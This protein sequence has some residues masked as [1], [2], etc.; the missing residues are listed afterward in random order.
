VYGESWPRVL[1][2]RPVLRCA[3]TPQPSAKESVARMESPG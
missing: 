3:V 2:L 1:M